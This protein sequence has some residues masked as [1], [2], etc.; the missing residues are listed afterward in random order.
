MEPRLSNNFAICTLVVLFLVFNACSKTDGQQPVANEKKTTLTENDKRRYFEDNFAFTYGSGY[1][2]SD[3]TLS[4][5]YFMRTQYP[6]LKAENISNALIYALEEEY[7]NPAQIDS[8]RQWFRITVYPC[9]R[10]PY[11]IVVEKQRDKTYLTSK[12]TNG[13]G[14]YYCGSLDFAVTKIYSDSFFENV[15][16]KMNQLDFWQLG[17][18]TSCGPGFDGETWTIEGIENG[19]YNIISRWVPISCDEKATRQIG[20]LGEDLRIQTHLTFFDSLFMVAPFRHKSVI[21]N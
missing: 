21:K 1:K 11:C 4:F 19:K 20:L 12:M 2:V 5:K 16:R 13:E 7:I 18:D 17:S 10:K 8:G 9:Y 3:T 6:D 15:S 14:G